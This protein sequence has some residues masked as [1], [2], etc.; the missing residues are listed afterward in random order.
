MAMTIRLRIVMN[1]SE[2]RK[3]Y[4]IVNIISKYYN[5]VSI[6]LEMFYVILQIMR[7]FATLNFL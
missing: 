5:Q 1:S 3:I 6:L 7:V 4:I 2:K